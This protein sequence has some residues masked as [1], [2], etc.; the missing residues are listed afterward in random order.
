M[1]LKKNGSAKPA[2]KLTLLLVLLLFNSFLI[3]FFLDEET[4]QLKQGPSLIPTTY[5][6]IAIEANARTLVKNGGVYS[7]WSKDMYVRDAYILK[8]EGLSSE[9]S[10]LKA[11][12]Q[13][14]LPSKK[15][16]VA[17]PGAQT[18]R[19]LLQKTFEILPYGVRKNFTK[20]MRKY[21]EIH[22]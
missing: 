5:K 12:L 21:Y 17:I 11:N 10:F 16:F 3:L 1:N 15:Y 8:E 9:E 2:Q 20:K 22:Y 4:P 14:Q 6:I 18:N 7:L 19:A 13:N